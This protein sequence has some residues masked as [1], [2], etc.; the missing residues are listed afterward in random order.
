MSDFRFNVSHLAKITTRSRA[1]LAKSGNMLSPYTYAVSRENTKLQGTYRILMLEYSS[2]D[3][4]DY[5]SW[6]SDSIAQSIPRKD[7]YQKQ[8]PVMSDPG[9]CN[10]TESRLADSMANSKAQRMG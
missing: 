3:N 1:T 2:V 9:S 7:R 10:R 6:R 4:I 8:S 5:V